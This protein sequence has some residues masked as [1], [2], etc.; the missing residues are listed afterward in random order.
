MIIKHKLARVMG[1]GAAVVAASG[2]FGLTGVAS[3]STAKAA[4]VTSVSHQAGA[5]IGC[6]DNNRSLA[7]EIAASGNFVETA[8]VY[9]E[10]GIK[11]T[12]RYSSDYG[13]AWGL[14]SGA[15]RDGIM[16][17][18]IWLDRSADGGASWQGYLGSISTYGLKSS[19]Y[20]GTYSMVN[21]NA[22]R[23]C[24]RDSIYL[25]LPG[26]TNSPPHFQPIF[27]TPWFFPGQP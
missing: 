14:L 27:C 21:Y 13:C 10:A 1:I 20:T 25:P 3:A 7:K 12:L 11:I 8:S 6:S 2:A 17:G 4:T 26:R 23:A 16:A 18:Y 15:P 22:I 24:G 5:A 19:T 9:T